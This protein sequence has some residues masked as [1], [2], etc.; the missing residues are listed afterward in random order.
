MFYNKAEG[1]FVLFFRFKRR[2]SYLLKLIGIVFL[3]MGLE[4]KKKRR[5]ATKKSETKDFVG[6]VENLENIYDLNFTEQVRLIG[7][8]M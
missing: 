6:Y 1:I 5:K 4:L 8:G 3:K 7:S 2:K